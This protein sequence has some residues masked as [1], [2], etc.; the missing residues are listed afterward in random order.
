MRRPPDVG[1][2]GVGLLGGIAV[3]QPTLLQ[4]GAHLRSPAEL[5]DERGVE[6]RL[7]DAQ[8]GVDEQPVTIEALDVVALVGASVAP[9][10]DAIGVHGLHEQRAGHGPAE[11]GRV[12]VRL[13]GR[14]DVESAALQG[15]QP[16]A[17][18]FRPTVDDPGQF[19]AVL[20]RPVGHA[21]RDR[22]RRTDRGQPCRRRGS[23]L[24]HASRRPPPR[25]RGRRRRRSR[26]ARRPA[27]TT[28]C[29]Q[30]SWPAT[31]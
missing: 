3:G 26:C 21:T 7:V 19:G 27:A 2:R 25:C 13:A 17:D 9:D 22:A 6:P 14:G 12:E 28:G 16:L 23:I 31:L 4:E 15:H 20:L 18:Q 5:V 30:S 8:L 1:I 11:R 29:A 24:W 10:V